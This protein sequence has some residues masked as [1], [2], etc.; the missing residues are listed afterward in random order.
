MGRYGYLSSAMDYA[1]NGQLEKWIHLYLSKEGDGRNP[2]FS[3]G[4]KLFKRY[5]LGPVKMPLSMFTRCC[6]PEDSMEWFE[7]KEVFDKRVG[8]LQKAI[9][10]NADMPPLIVNYVDGGFVLNDGNHR[11]EAYLRLGISEY[12]VIIWITEEDEYIDFTEK[13]P[14]YTIL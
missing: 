7:S 5:Y 2:A 3:E 6:G 12:Y 11:F 14:E 1:K 9:S 8:D 4:L 13:Y 10:E